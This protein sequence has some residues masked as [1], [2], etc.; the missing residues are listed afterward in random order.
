MARARNIKPGLF[1]NEI[2]GVADPLYTL[3]F[4]GLWILAD[5]DG[6][7]EDRPLRIKAEIFPYRDGINPS[8]MLDW[9]RDNEFIVRYA[10]DGKKYIQIVNFEKHQNPHKNESESEIPAFD[11]SCSTSEKIGTTSDFVGSTRADSLFSDSLIPDS[12]NLIPDSLTTDSSVPKTASPSS[13]AKRPEANSTETWSV[14]S[15]AYL[16]R[17]GTE[18]V[19]NA[20]VNGQLSNFVK[21]LGALEAPAVAAWYV[22]HNGRYYVQNCHPV[23][24][25]LKD[26]E[27]LRTEWATRRQ[28]TA[29]E[30]MQADKTQTN[31][32]SFAP[33]IEE[34]RRRE[35]QEAAN[36]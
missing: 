25:M 22:S 20:T 9:L 21:R 27:K 32:N 3:M 35:A 7:L 26:A 1:K 29:A 36:A 4:E 15:T 13:V 8:D 28:V 24:A 12:L 31:L 19:R 33:M 6:R 17:Y 5:R 14:Y 2:L 34:A 10:I 16:G 18:P 30:A 11:E 23:S